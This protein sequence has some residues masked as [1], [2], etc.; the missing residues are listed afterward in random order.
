MYITESGQ[1]VWYLENPLVRIKHPL[2]EFQVIQRYS[3]IIN[4]ADDYHRFVEPALLENKPD[5]WH[6]GDL[7]VG[8]S[9]FD[10]DPLAIWDLPVFKLMGV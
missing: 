4:N 2:S 7:S 9:D 10:Y 6:I 8:I 5:Y 1:K 3:W